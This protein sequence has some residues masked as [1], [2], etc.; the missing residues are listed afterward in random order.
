MMSDVRNSTAAVQ[1]GRYK[2]VNTV[3]AARRLAPPSH[4][5]IHPCDCVRDLG[6]ADEKDSFRLVPA[7]RRL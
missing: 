5:L 4:S 3:G 2:N 1:S 6:P 7:R